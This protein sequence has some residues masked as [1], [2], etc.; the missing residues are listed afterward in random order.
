M[1]TLSFNKETRQFISTNRDTLSKNELLGLKKLSK[2]KFGRIKYDDFHSL[3]GETGDNLNHLNQLFGLR[4][5]G[6]ITE[7][8]IYTDKNQ[9]TREMFVEITDLGKVLVKLM[10]K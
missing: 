8:Y 2:M 6:F 9:T 1:K 3:F 7:I 5:N 4:D 10:N